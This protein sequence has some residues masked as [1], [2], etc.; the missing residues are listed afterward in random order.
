MI[1]AFS[2]FAFGRFV[3]LPEFGVGLSMAIRLD[4][5]HVRALLLPATM[6]LL[7]HWTWYLPERVARALSLAPA[8]R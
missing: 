1:A 3:G 2:G 5:T 7:G 4:A 8:K 6:K